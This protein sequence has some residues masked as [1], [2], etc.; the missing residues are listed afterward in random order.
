[1]NDILIR[2]ACMMDGSAL[3]TVD[4]LVGNGHI[5]QV[6]DHIAS[7]RPTTIVDATGLTALPAL[8]DMHVHLR[9]PGYEYK[10]TILSGTQAAAKAGYTLLCS[11]PNLRPAPDSREHLDVQR[12]IIARDGRV[13]VIPYASITVGQ[14]G[15]GELVDMPSLAPY[16][17]GFSDDGRGIQSDELMQRAMELAHTLSRPIVAHCEVDSLLEGGYIHKGEYARQHNHRGICSRSE[18]QQVERDIE[19]VRRIGCQYHVC[20]ISTLESAA[21][22][23]KAKSEGL[24]VTCETAPHYLLLSDSDLREEGRY[25]M[26][27]PLRSELDRRALLEALL[28]GTIDAIATDHAPH[29]DEEKSRGLEASA[30]GVSGLECAFPVLYTRLVKEG[31][32]SLQRLVELMSG[33]ARTILHLPQISLSVGSRA[34]IALFDLNAHYRIDSSSFLSKG[35]STPFDGWQV[36]A[37]NRMTIMKG[38][39]IYQATK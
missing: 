31:I 23:R 34:D 6:A 27:P 26:N 15:S 25:K 19:L 10:E 22:I 18:W 3:K 32:I 21:L 9:Q 35:H 14:K 12:E 38:E 1:M 13:E 7:E 30:M 8:S 2:N 17:A 39:I 29:S 4:I 20:H 24:P 5:V 37:L 33:A 11:M 16:V 28:D 36:D